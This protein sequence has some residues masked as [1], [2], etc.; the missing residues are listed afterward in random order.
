MTANATG[1]RHIE[2]PLCWEKIDTHTS[3]KHVISF[4]NYK[5]KIILK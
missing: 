3:I 2:N 1:K 4:L 5:L